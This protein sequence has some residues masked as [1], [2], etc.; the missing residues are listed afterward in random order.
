[1]SDKKYTVLIDHG[2]GT[3]RI[4]NMEEDFER[5]WGENFIDIIEIDGE[6]D[7]PRYTKKEAQKI[8]D[9]YFPVRYV[10]TYNAGEGKR[11]IHR[12]TQGNWKGSMFGPHE[13]YCADFSNI[14]DAQEYILKKKRKKR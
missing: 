1:M 14:E 10:V 11:Y 3:G 6:Y 8:L 5:R 2:A 4:V 13:N 9:W 7:V 12:V